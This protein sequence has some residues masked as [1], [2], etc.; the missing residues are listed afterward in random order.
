MTPPPL[1]AIFYHMDPLPAEKLINNLSCYFQSRRDVAFAF[2]FGSC[3]AGT[4]GPM[5]DVDL[6]VYFYP[7]SNEFEIEDDVSYQ[8]EDTIWA[9]TETICG[10]EVDLLVM[11]RAPARLVSTALSEGVELSMASRPLFLKVLLAAGSLFDEYVDFTR[12]FL[13][14]KA[15]SRSLSE[16]DRDRLLR[17]ID[18]IETELADAIQFQELSYETYQ[19]DSGTRRNVERWVENCV[20]ASIDA[21]K[22]IV[23]SRK[24]HIPQT[25]R[26]TILRLK[27][28]D[29]FS[30]EA[31]D[32]LAG[33]TRL[34]NILAHEYL[35]LRFDH[36]R[37]FVDQAPPLYSRFIILLRNFLKQD[38]G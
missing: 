4:S 27:T 25:Y 17:I 11:N 35:D 5:S 24:Q 18:F 36:I 10:R 6:G 16:T 23:A 26:E 2:L 20:N 19:N 12:S 21:A 1:R 14:I 8:G 3:A 7:K 34:R 15:R 32:T 28:I 31:I 13:E 9:D 38:D 37:R 22:L 30:P 29:I 33:F